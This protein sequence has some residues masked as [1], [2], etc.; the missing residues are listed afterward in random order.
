M[1]SLIQLS[2]SP[3]DVGQSL[4][5]FGAEAA[6]AHLVS[7]HAWQSVMAWKGTLQARAMSAMVREHF[8]SIWNELDG[9]AAG[10]ELP[11]EEVV[12]WNCRGDV[13]AMAPDGCTTVQVPLARGPRITHNED[14]DPAFAGHCA[15][16]EI[17]IDQGSHFA[18]FVYPASIPG[19]TFAVTETGLVMTVNNL[20]WRQVAVGVPRMVLTRAVL[21][22]GSV[23]A[24]LSLLRTIPRAGGF[25]L[26][27]AQRGQPDLLSVEFS[28]MG[29]SSQPVQIPSLH[30]NHAIHASMR[31]F[32]QIITKSSLCRQQSGDAMLDTVQDPLAILADQ[33]N[34]DFPVYR[35]ALDDSDGENTMAT[36]D[37]HVGA[38][39][40]RWQVYERPGGP[41][42]FQLIDARIR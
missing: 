39:A 15:I 37:M 38:D 12:L 14:G 22:Q 26:S 41:A 28:T 33:R 1:L 3:Y 29:V 42:R 24:A 30:A 2:G 36:A 32:P 4:G 17:A 31:D 19:H 35:N 11:L 16:A 20:R 5:K 6:H 23:P 13:W 27:L 21:D 25:H 18:S 10:L 7:S 9:L 34:A 40:V 8:P